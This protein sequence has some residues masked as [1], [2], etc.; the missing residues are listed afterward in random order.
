MRLRKA[1]AGKFFLP[2]CIEFFKR[3]SKFLCILPMTYN[4]SK[5]IRFVIRNPELEEPP[6]FLKKDA[7]DS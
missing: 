6:H 2:A 1:A 3:G 7:K 5:S 4:I